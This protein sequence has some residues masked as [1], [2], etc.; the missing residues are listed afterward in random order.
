LKNPFVVDACSRSNP[1][2]KNF[3]IPDVVIR[4]PGGCENSRMSS[5]SRK[6]WQNGVRSRLSGGE[7]KVRR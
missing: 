7:V 1:L 3:W 4:I 2:L 6:V 5:A